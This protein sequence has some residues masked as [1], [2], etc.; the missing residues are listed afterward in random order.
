MSAAEIA[1]AAGMLLLTAIAGVISGTWAL[2]KTDR[3]LTE[4]IDKAKLDI[5]R[6]LDEE[7]DSTVQRFGETVTAIRTKMTDMELWNRDNFVDKSTFGTFQANLADF[8]KRFE[9]KIDRRFDKI[10]AKLDDR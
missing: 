9:D 3:E 6:R 1:I 7:T 8:F 2:A 4:K 5:E 10:D